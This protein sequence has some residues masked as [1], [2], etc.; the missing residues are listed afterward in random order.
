MEETASFRFA[1]KSTFRLG[2]PDGGDGGR[3]GSVILE[4][5]EGLNTLLDFKYKKIYRGENGTHGQG[6]N[7]MGKDGKDLIVRVPPGTVVKDRAT[8]R[9]IGDLV[10][11]KEQLVVAQGGRGGRG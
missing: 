11:H 4:V 5:D 6:A 8:G 9:I 3:G 7:Q 1:A 2:G 10:N